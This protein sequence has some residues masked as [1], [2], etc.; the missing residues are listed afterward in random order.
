[1]KK[2]IYSF[3]LITLSL[4][5]FIIIYLSTF[6]VETSRFNNV[7]INE[8]KKK[9]SS[10]DLSLNKIKIKF[11][12]KKVQIYLSTTEPKIVY[13][14]IKIP[15][16][17]IKIYSKISSILKSKSEVSQAIFSLKNFNIKDPVKVYW[18]EE[19]I[20]ILMK[21]ENIFT[22]RVKVWDTEFL[23]SDKKILISNK[24]QDW[25]EKKILNDLT[26]I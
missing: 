26:P 8:I 24:L 6:G 14:N 13:Q 12:L 18:G 10:I 19:P 7:L 2:I 1:M 15:I 4:I 16:T 22:P 17:D 23:D 3:L 20:G 11:D 5:I 25:L 21:G 9:N